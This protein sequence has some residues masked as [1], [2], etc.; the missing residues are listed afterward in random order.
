MEKTNLFLF[1]RGYTF[2]DLINSLPDVSSFLVTSIA[3]QNDLLGMNGILHVV[4]WS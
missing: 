4:P 2:I 1:I 3:D